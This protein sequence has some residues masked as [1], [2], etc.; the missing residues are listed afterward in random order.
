[1]ELKFLDCA[2]NAVTIST[3]TDGSGG[4]LQ[5]STGCTNAI[6]A[7]AQ[8]DGESNRDGRKFVMKSIYFSGMV[9]TT[10]EATENAA[11][12]ITGY[13]FALVLDTQVNKATVVSEDVFINPSSTSLAMIP[14]PLRNL[15]NSTRYRIL[16]SKYIRPG[17]AF[18][19]NDGA[20]TGSVNNQVAPVISL[21][22]K[23]S[24]NVECTGT[25]ADV[26]SVSNNAI[27]VVA[28]AAD[29]AQTPVFIGKSRLRFMG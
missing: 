1:M 19:F 9:A 17:G 22:W 24:I 20:T 16:D 23:G 21:S 18:A 29:G 10:A 3:S 15:Q 12:E 26:A 14:Q 25:T 27:H 8:G 13:Y 6:S 28:Y 11:H 5:P 4:E 7:P 2:W